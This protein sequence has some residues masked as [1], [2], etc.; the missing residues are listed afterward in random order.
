[1]E[2]SLFLPHDLDEQCQVHLQARS[3]QWT[4]SGIWGWCGGVLIQP[5]GCVQPDHDLYA[6]VE[7]WGWQSSSASFEHAGDGLTLISLQA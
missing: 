2:H 7:Q 4:Q 5:W 6:Q 1:M 3:G